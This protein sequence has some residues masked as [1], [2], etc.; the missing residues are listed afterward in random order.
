LLHAYAK[1]G[2]VNQQGK[3]IEKDPLFFVLLA[4]MTVMI[5]LNTTT[6]CVVHHKLLYSFQS[7]HL[8]DSEQFLSNKNN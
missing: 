1:I 8:Y 5:N 6:I 7:L 4:K 2:Q 3:I